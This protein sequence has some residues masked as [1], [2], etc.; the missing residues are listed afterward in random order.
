MS[1]DASEHLNARPPV[2]DYRTPPV[3]PRGKTS[4]AKVVAWTIG[5]MLGG[6]LILSC[7]IPFLGRAGPRAKKVKC[8]SNLRSIGQVIAMYQYDHR[9]WPQTFGEILIDGDLEAEVFTCP[10]GDA[11]R[12]SV[13]TTQAAALSLA[14]PQHCSYIYFPPPPG[15]KTVSP[16]WIFAIERMENHSRTGINVLFGD[17][18][19]EWLDKKAAEFIISELNAGRNPP[20]WPTTRP[21]KASSA[22]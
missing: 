22:Q 14:N 1:K 19:V 21:A 15:A 13:P 7:I 10:Q 11:R 18:H 6:L 5:A 8:A 12:A 17:G 3:D 20:R 4:P 2:I 16:N 9:V